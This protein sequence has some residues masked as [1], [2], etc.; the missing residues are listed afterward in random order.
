MLKERYV[1]DE[2]ASSDRI[3]ASA[4]ELFVKY[5]ACQNVWF[6]IAMRIVA[7][8]L[9]AAL[10]S[11][12]GLEFTLGFTLCTSLAIAAIRPFR[13]HQVND[14]QSFCFFC[15]AIAAFAFSTGRVLTARAALLAP[16]VMA[17]AQALKPDGPEALALRLFQD[18]EA[19]W[20]SL[21]QGETWEP[22]LRSISL[23]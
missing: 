3:V 2:V 4:K 8:A 6:E 22:S 17:A 1:L 19:Q 7:V 5:A 12:N 13:Q 20:P 15:L 11:E 10:R 23:L 21:Q 18:A 9:V 16:C 14:L